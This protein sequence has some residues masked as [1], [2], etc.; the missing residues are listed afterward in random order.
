MDRNSALLTNKDCPALQTEMVMKVSLFLCLMA[1]MPMHSAASPPGDMVKRFLYSTPDVFKLHHRV[2]YRHDA[3]D[4]Y[5]SFEQNFPVDKEVSL[6]VESNHPCLKIVQEDEETSS[7]SKPLLTSKE[8]SEPQTWHIEVKTICHF[9][10]A[11]L[12]VKMTYSYP[13]NN[14]A[15]YIADHA[16]NYPD[17][18]G[19]KALLER[20]KKLKVQRRKISGIFFY[21]EKFL[22]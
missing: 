20:I 5:L 14:A 8:E 12:A 10:L 2:V 15:R 13:K 7:L 16:D 19:R 1:L 11:S 17:R 22:N 9:G 3:A 21:K 18:I 4:V 6:I